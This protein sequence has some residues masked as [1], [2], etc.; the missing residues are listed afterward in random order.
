[1]KE[2]L[3]TALRAAA[4]FYAQFSAALSPT[5]QAA[6]GTLAHWSAKDT[7]AHITFWN[8]NFRQQI[9]DFAADQTLMNF[10]SESH[11][12]ELNAFNDANFARWHAATWEAVQTWQTDTLN[13]IIERVEHT[14]EALLL[15]KA[16]IWTGER[17][18]FQAALNNVWH[19][20][21]L[22]FSDYCIKAGQLEHGLALHQTALQTTAQVSANNHGS[23]VYGLAGF[24]ARTGQPE[25]ALTTLT[26]AIT[27][28]PR[29]Q[30]WAADDPEFDTLRPLP[31]FQALLKA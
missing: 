15:D 3:L 14:D 6:T 11:P 22:H 31:A 16:F 24:Y 25:L 30:I 7:L 26:Q 28:L 19:H 23:R 2:Q 9:S 27:L 29:V 8:D 21:M 4:P 18:Q 1:M 20:A 10:P 17:S 5:E 12:D 13:A